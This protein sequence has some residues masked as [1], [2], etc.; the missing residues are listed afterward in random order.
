MAKWT[1]EK[2][3]ALTDSELDEMLGLEAQRVEFKATL[4]EAA[5]LKGEKK[6]Q[7]EENLT[8]TLNPTVYVSGLKYDLERA[9]SDTSAEIKSCCCG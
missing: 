9:R 3:Q 1:V 5:S 8:R 6:T 4:A 7:F 2:A